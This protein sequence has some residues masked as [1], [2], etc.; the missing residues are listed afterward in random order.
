M[1]F[2]IDLFLIYFYS[3]NLL[4]CLVLLQR[5]FCLMVINVIGL[6][7][8]LVSNATAN[9]V[10]KSILCTF[11]THLSLFKDSLQALSSDN[12]LKPLSAY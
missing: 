6:F 5:S 9:F 7:M 1:R 4:G 3:R 2:F 8:F 10:L 12:C 11:G